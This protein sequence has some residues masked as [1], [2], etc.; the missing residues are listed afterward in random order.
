MFCI[1]QLNGF[2]QEKKSNMKNCIDG[3]WILKS[4]VTTI[5]KVTTLWPQL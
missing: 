2:L 1:N 4:V 5:E 3:Q